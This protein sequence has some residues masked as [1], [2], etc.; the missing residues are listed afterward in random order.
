MTSQFDPTAIVCWKHQ[1]ENA[2]RCGPSGVRCGADGHEK[3][4]DL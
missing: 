3:G 2:L 4:H 1:D